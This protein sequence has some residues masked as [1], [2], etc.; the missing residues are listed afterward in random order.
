VLFTPIETIENMKGT[1]TTLQC[2]LKGWVLALALHAQAADLSADD[3]FTQWE[4]SKVGVA[5]YHSFGVL[6]PTSGPT[7]VRAMSFSTSQEFADLWRYYAA[8]CGIHREFVEGKT[9]VI[10]G[11]NTLGSYFLVERSA[12]SKVRESV[13]GLRTESYSVS[14]TLRNSNEIESRPTAGT[15]V[16]WLR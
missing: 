11:T 16:V 2:V 9:Y 10:S 3:V 8:K 12:G 7:T 5:D 15:V 14:V 1:K 4:P 13:F 6:A